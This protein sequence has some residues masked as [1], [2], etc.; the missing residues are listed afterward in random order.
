MTAMRKLRGAWAAWRTPEAREPVQVEPHPEVVFLVADSG[1]DVRKAFDMLPGEARAWRTLAEMEA[2]RSRIWWR[3]G[4]IWDAGMCAGRAQ[5]YRAA[6][7]QVEDVLIEAL[8]LWD[9]YERQVR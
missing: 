2:A 9:A 8:G 6:A 1:A 3:H 4:R 7:E 5:G